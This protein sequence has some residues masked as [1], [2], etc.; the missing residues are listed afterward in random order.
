MVFAE[1]AMVIV[2]VGAWPTG[3]GSHRECSLDGDR[4]PLVWACGRWGHYS[5]WFWTAIA[6]G[7]RLT[8]KS[9]TGHHH[10]ASPICRIDVSQRL[11]QH[12][13]MTERVNEASLAFAVLP[14]TCACV[15]GC[16]GCSGGFK[17]SVDVRDPEH[18]LVSRAGLLF[19]SAK[20]AHD[21]FSSLVGESELYSMTVTDTDVLYEPEHIHIPGD[22]L[23]HIGDREHWDYPGPGR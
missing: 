7:A 18:H 9:A 6:C 5:A 10:F 13:T 8:A 3:R 20:L 16:A 11:S 17:Y 23:A 19:A 22:R 12:P 4:A 21:Q 1:S 2:T 14:V 15:R